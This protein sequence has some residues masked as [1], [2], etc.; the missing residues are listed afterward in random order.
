VTFYNGSTSLGTGALTAG[1]A[2]LNNVSFSA[3]GTYSLTAVYGGDTTYATSTSSAVGV[4]VTASGA[5]G[6]T[7]AVSAA[8]GSSSSSS[9]LTVNAGAAVTLT[10]SV[11]PA[12]GTTTATGTVEFFDSGN[13]VTC[14]NSSSTSAALSSGTAT[15]TTSF[16]G[17]GSSH[18]V[19]A[20][21]LGDENYAENSESNTVDITVASVTTTLAIS[22][23]PSETT[24]GSGVGLAAI[25]TPVG[26]AGTVDF[27]DV[28]TSTDLGSATLSAQSVAALTSTSL[29]DVETHTIRATFGSG[30]DSGTVKIDAASGSAAVVSNFTST[31][32]SCG[33][34]TD[35]A[36]GYEVLTSGTLVTNNGSYNLA[37]GTNENVICV[38]G[39]SAS[40]TLIDP[41]ITSDAAVTS[42]DS[43]DA[44]FY[45]LDAAVL[46]YNGG[47][48][49]I[50]GATITPSAGANG[51]NMIYSYGTGTV[52][53]SNSTLDATAG[54]SNNH[55]IYASGGGTIVANNV[56]AHSTG[57][58]SSIIA[59]DRGGG[60]LTV[61][62]GTYE[63][64]SGKTAVVYSTGSI[65]VNNATLIGED[66]EA[67]GIEGD[68]QIYLNNVMMT[69]GNNNTSSSA[70]DHR[71]V[72][73][74]QSGSG[75]ALNSTCESIT[76][77]DCLVMN[78]GSY[79]YTDTYNG[80]SDPNLN[81]TAFEVY[82]QTSLIYLT[83]ATI[84][85]QCNTL[86]V[87]SYN[88][89]WSNN[90]A[91]GYATIKAYGTSL[92]GNVIAGYG[93]LASGCASRDTSSTADIY[94]YKDSSNNGSTLTGA[95]NGG[96]TG[97]TAAAAVAGGTTLTM[98]TSSNWVVTGTSYL[99]SLT[100]ADAT[101]SNITCQNASP[102]VYVNGT[103]VK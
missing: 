100:D 29:T 67:A 61:N 91:W 42:A 65:T 43:G 44:S 37:S 78:G 71:G 84:T 92:T 101:Y 70:T 5:D 6:T 79:T 99:T 57:G 77:G 14:A 98:D 16:S 85:N 62:G 9:S 83:D 48:V 66:G 60:T 54:A 47:N 103:A 4:T 93:C 12:T 38:Q 36:E 73:L 51:A 19:T 86:L 80:N 69:T 31:G 46:D 41:T 32:A 8:S 87:S 40:L 34:A 97:L 3:A 94:L 45:G 27:Y 21:Y 18:S 15:C 90:N 72:L 81:C 102:C 58:T 33:Y 95:I 25:V 56:N 24:A 13:A 63:S 26:T 39:T 88:D 75:D 59:T 96:K 68:N 7:V 22:V 1:V 76:T 89:Q 23:S 50:D 10:A 49:T 11:S 64:D 2:V 74:L 35:G 30:T 82:N 20:T 55:G 17:A 28:T 53:V 52:T